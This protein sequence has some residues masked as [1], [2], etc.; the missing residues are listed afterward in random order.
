MKLSTNAVALA[1]AIA[2]QHATAMD[3]DFRNFEG[4]WESVV[5]P[6]STKNTVLGVFTCK[7]TGDFLKAVC[8]VTF[9]AGDDVFCEQRYRPTNGLY[10]TSV[11]TGKFSLDQF[12]A[13]TGETGALYFDLQCCG[14]GGC[15]AYPYDLAAIAN[16]LPSDSPLLSQLGP[17]TEIKLRQVPGKNANNIRGVE[18]IYPAPAGL[19]ISSV[20]DLYMKTA[21][22]FK[23]SD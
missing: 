8:D 14:A 10:P 11:L 12:D 1:L 17:Q 4:L 21:G 2:A 20:T 22:G 13:E 16:G 6:I 3:F 7:A 19:G 5:G 18:V 23:S 15:K 9:A